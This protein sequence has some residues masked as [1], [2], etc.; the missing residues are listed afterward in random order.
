MAITFVDERRQT[1]GGSVSG[2]SGLTDGDVLFALLVTFNTSP[3]QNMQ[4]PNDANMW[5]AIGSN[6]YPSRY[7]TLLLFRRWSTGDPTSYDFRDRFGAGTGQFQNVDSASIIA[8]RG[9]AGRNLRMEIPDSASNAGTG[10]CVLPATAPYAVT[11]GPVLLLYWLISE[12]VGGTPTFDAA[13][14]AA[15]TKCVGGSLSHQ[16]AYEVVTTPGATWPSRT[17][18]WATPALRPLLT[19]AAPRDWP[20]V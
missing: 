7:S 5:H 13:L 1:S 16:W 3:G 4:Y 15:G 12:T 14:T 11:T 17:C 6:S 9:M 18:S 2:L 8:F 19:R 20:M 10:N